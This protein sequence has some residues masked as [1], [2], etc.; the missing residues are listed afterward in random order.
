MKLLLTLACGILPFTCL[1][2]QQSFSLTPN[3]VY[4]DGPPDMYEIRGEANIKNLSST[5]ETFHWKRTIIRLDDQPNCVTSVA[6]PFIEWFPAVSE[7]T[8]TLDPQQEGP[9]YVSLLDPNASNCCAIVHIKITKTSGTPDSIDAYYYLRVCQPLAVSEAQKS[10]V[11]LYPN[12]A[13]RYFALKNAENVYQITLCDGNG[14][15]L[16]KISANADNQYDIESLTPGSYYLVL[17]N[18]AGAILQVLNFIK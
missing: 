14:K 10:G 9:M 12:P 7:K 1:L 17:E 18:R 13:A 6:D 8:F 16:R 4:A 15:M 3:P 2:A 11:V 5:A